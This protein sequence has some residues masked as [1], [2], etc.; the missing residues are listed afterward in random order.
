MNDLFTTGSVSV[1]GVLGILAFAVSLIVQMTKELPGLSKIPTQLYAIIVSLVVNVAALYVYANYTGIAI[2]N[3]YIVL[4]VFAS[5]V[6]S[7]VSINGWDTLNQLYVRFTGK[8]PSDDN[9][10]NG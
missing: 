3:Y 7:Y 4:A 8:N 6:V 5:F 2:A 1:L 9:I 10:L